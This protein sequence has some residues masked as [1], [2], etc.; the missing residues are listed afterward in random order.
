MHG[1]LSA[2]AYYLVYLVLLPVTILGY[3]TWVGGAILRG[4]GSGISGTAQGPLFARYFEHRL[5]VREDEAAARV[6]LALPGVPPLGLKLFT[7]PMILGHSITGYVPKT[8]RY[9]YTDEIAPQ[10]VAAARMTFFDAEVEL[11]TA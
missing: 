10:V 6:M 4:R 7:W 11:L 5:G 1:F 3:V 2:V 9:P 8:F